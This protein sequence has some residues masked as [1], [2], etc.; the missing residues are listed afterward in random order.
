[1]PILANSQGEAM[2]PLAEKWNRRFENP[3]PEALM[4]PLSYGLIMRTLPDT[5]KR[6]H[7]KA[8]WITQI[9]IFAASGC[10]AFLLRFDLEL[11][12]AYLRALLWGVAVW[13]VVKSAVFRASVLRARCPPGRAPSG[14]RPGAGRACG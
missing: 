6:I 13:V 7:R 3:V 4:P 11:P 14:A 12:H 2:G 8:V 9:A 1:M 5:L 10:L